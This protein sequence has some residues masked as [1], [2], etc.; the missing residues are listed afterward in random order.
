MVAPDRANG[1]FQNNLSLAIR[2][3]TMSALHRYSNRQRIQ[4]AVHAESPPFL[5]CAES[6]LK[7]RRIGIEVLLR[8]TIKLGI[9]VT[10]NW[11]LDGL[12]LL[13]RYT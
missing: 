5:Y 3:S 10:G 13:Y 9:A 11:K 4:I 1:G 12:L 6:A 2:K 8:R 7:A